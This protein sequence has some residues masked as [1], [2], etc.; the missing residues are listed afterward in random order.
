ML[1][2]L[3]RPDAPACFFAGAAF[4]VAPRSAKAVSA[5]EKAL[6]EAEEAAAKEKFFSAEAEAKER[7]REEALAK[8]NAAKAKEFKER[9]ARENA[10]ADGACRR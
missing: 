10:E 5:A 3:T 6:E 1:L 7:A 9:V 2:F 8:A 4:L